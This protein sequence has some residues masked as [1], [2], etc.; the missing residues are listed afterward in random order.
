MSLFEV[1]SC[2]SSSAADP[3][4]DTR[5][6]RLSSAPMSEPQVPKRARVVVVGGGIIGCSVAYHLAHM[7]CKDVVL[8]ERDR[9]TSG[10]TWHAAGLM[11][12]FGSTSET[13]T[14]MRKYTRDLYARLEAETGLATGFRPIGR[15]TAFTVFAVT[16][17]A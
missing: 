5:A 10:T 4:G 13:S 16:G 11:V 8:L 9:L 1:I 17:R 6:A 3:K 7:G 14:E 12:C 15:I 2:N